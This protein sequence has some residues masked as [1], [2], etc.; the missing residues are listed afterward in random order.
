MPIFQGQWLNPGLSLR[1]ILLRVR[2][3]FVDPR[4]SAFEETSV[5]SVQK[6][7]AWVGS[8]KMEIL[9]LWLLDIF[10]G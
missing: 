10:Q 8:R 6:T 9:I 4:M 3:Q 7:A 1:F 2:Q 5:N